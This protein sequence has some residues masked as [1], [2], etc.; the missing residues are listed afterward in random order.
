MYE[1]PR[2]GWLTTLART[3]R[4][5]IGVPDYDNYVAH[6]RLNHPGEPVMSYEEFFRQR[7]DARYERGRSRCC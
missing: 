1:P 5:A 3:A 4:L 6:R 7:L 2:P